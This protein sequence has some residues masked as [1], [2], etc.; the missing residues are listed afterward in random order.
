MQVVGTTNATTV[1]YLGSS[2]SGIGMPVV[3]AI[4]FA[5]LCALFILGCFISKLLG[6]SCMKKENSSDG[7]TLAQKKAIGNLIPPIF[8][9]DK[10]KDP[11][12][13]EDLS[14]HALQK[15][16]RLEP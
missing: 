14:D 9:T 10:V 11:L 16:Q 7:G 1:Q 6:S 5:V 15:Y 13:Q 3:L 4:V 2:N 12:L 8:Y